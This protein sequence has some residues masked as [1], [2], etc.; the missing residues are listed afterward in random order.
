MAG[1]TPVVALLCCLLLVAGVAADLRWSP[2]YMRR[3]RHSVAAG[4]PD[5]R[6]RMYRLTLLLAWSAAAVATVLLAT[7]GGG[8]V[9]AGFRLPEEEGLDHW[10]GFLT[11]LLMLSLV[12]VVLARTGRGPRLVGDVDVLL[13]RTGSERRWYAAVAVT[14]G[15]TEEIVYR[16][17]ALAVLLALL[18]GGQW[19]ALLVAAALFGLGHAYQGRTGVLVTAL[20]A[21]GLGRLY[22]DTGSLLPG[23][24]VHALIDLRVLLLAT[25]PAQGQTAA[26]AQQ[27]EQV[28]P[29]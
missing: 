17:F 7:V 3:V 29:Q 24:V 8:L 26:P 22:L 19:P 14:A 9:E 18:P 23:M 21:V 20:L 5:A 1:M 28:Q 4:D 16:A 2:G 11:G 12:L 27:A 13:P 6:T 10:S 25:A 15:I